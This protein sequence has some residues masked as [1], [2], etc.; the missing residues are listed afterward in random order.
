MNIVIK[1]VYAD[2]TPVPLSTVYP[3]GNTISI[4]DFISKLIHPVLE[5]AALLILFYIF[6]AGWKYLTSGG[7]KEELAK[8]RAMV[9]HAIIGA[10]LLLALF[11]VM[12]TLPFL[13]G[14][15]LKGF[16]IIK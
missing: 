4:G 11:V 3:F 8:A 15:T 7:N 14:D 5:I 9:L 1:P 16:Q 13:L 6:F 12:Y 2:A 10:I